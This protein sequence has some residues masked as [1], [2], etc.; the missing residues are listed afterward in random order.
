V[1]VVGGGN[2]G[3]EAAL[4]AARLAADVTLLTLRTTRLGE[5]SCN[6]A[7][8]GVAKGTLVRELA[9]LGGAMPRSADRAELQF[10][11]L[12]VSKGPAVW[13]PRKQQD[14]QLYMALQRRELEAAG[15]RVLETEA[16]SL[17]G[18]RE[19]VEGVRTPS[20]VVPADAVVIAAGTFLG[21]RLFRGRER[22]R[23]GR[24]GECPSDS[25]EHDLRTRMF[26]VKRFKTGTPPRLVAATLDTGRMSRQEEDGPGY[27]FSPHPEGNPPLRTGRPCWITFTNSGTDRAAR[28]GMDTSPLFGGCIGG[29]GPRYCPSF[30]DKVR[31]FPE[32]DSH[33][34]FVE[35]MG[36]DGRLVYP[37]GLSTSLSRE[38][39][40]RMLQTVP[41]LEKA[42]VARF[43]Y[44]VEY[45]WLEQGEFDRT[46]RARGMENLFFAGQVCG[47]SGYEEAAALGLLAGANAARVAADL[48]PREADRMES[49]LGVMVDDLV[50]RGTD[51]PYRLFSSRSEN[52][53]HLRQDNAPVRMAE[54]RRSLF[55]R[56]PSWQEEWC[57]GLG[58]VHRIMVGARCRGR[59][60]AELARRPEM[61]AEDLAGLC[62]ELREYPADVLRTAVLDE[63]YGGYIRRARARRE[64]L[65]R[66]EEVSLRSVGDYMEIDL[67]TIEARQALN[68]Q[69]P[70]TLGEA[71]GIP[72]VR[73]SDLEGLM[74]H[75][76][77]GRST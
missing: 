30:E 18:P 35:P 60:L 66:M 6:P 72:S 19:R 13:G 70:R 67:I 33:R 5:L 31:R 48:Q 29:K 45:G 61:E 68:R 75:I 9:S 26:H 50:G 21:G 74:I 59:S 42:E 20:G 77:G 76:F 11:M 7:V 32:R 51:E 73:H 22:W 2:A 56:I 8:G 25:L 57:R 40:V 28:A 54:L 3:I 38:T 53:L 27:R 39:Q 36:A 37:S 4:A 12:N 34:V 14:L 24:V 43:G 16:L 71:A 17:E 1:V 15:V 44:A 55:G 23:G 58:E 65:A 10:R 52:R 63:K 49:Y 64:R 69:R 41:G 47:T 62:P 46:L